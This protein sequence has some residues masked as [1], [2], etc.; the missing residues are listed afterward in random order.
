MAGLNF[1][2]SRNLAQ[3]GK[4]VYVN[5]DKG[6]AFRLKYIGGGSVT[7]VT[8]VENTELVLVSAKDGVTSTDYYHWATP[9]TYTTYGAIVDAINAD[10]RFQAKILDGLSTSTAGDGTFIDGAVTAD[11]NGE[12]N[13]LSDT[14]NAIFMAARLS[15][16]RTFNTP[17]K[18][19]KGHRV[20][21]LEVITNL[22]LDTAAEANMFK[23]YECSNREG[24]YTETLIYQK[25]PTT[26]SSNT[27][28]WASGNGK[29][30]ANDG[31]DLLVWISDTVS[32]S[33]SI[34]V[35]GIAE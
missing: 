17:E 27:T 29:I 7:S 35:A 33:G 6:V 1:L 13:I 20:H 26:G 15:Y 10:G 9:A 19:R 2:H 34:S 18:I 11:A 4:I 22:T 31:A 3:K 5:D 21:L 32:I 14:S 28:N 25:T 23:I 12:Y 16:D 8:V 30:T 24:G